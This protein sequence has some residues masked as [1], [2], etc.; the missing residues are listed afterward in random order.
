MG[1]GSLSSVGLQ[2]P[3]NL[4]VV[5]LNNEHFGE[6]GMQTT[7]TAASVNLSDIAKASGIPSSWTIR[8]SSEIRITKEKLLH[9]EGPLI[10]RD[11]DEGRDFNVGPPS[12][13]RKNP[14][15][16]IPKCADE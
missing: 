4:A 10:L 9:A 1:L 16:A 7:H 6:T 11:Q 5:V 13:K 12:Q 3:E 15:K 14:S 8:E 2:Q